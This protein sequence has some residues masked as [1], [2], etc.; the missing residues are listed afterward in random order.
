MTTHNKYFNFEKSPYHDV[1]CYFVK[2]SDEFYNVIAKTKPATIAQHFSY[3]HAIIFLFGL[4]PE[5]FFEY[6]K[7]EYSAQIHRGGYFKAFT[8]PTIQDAF[9]FTNECER[10]FSKM[11]EE[12]YFD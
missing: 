8:F 5:H 1:E 4:S 9:K 2:F 6:I 7:S 3:Y 11:V 12:R 10:R